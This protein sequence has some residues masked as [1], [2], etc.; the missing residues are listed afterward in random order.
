MNINI[1]VKELE[2][3]KDAS[4]PE[5]IGDFI[6]IFQE[7]FPK[8]RYNAEN[9]QKPVRVGADIKTSGD[10]YLDE[11]RE[12]EAAIKFLE[13]LLEDAREEAVYRQEQREIE[14]EKEDLQKKRKEEASLIGQIQR[15]K[16]KKENG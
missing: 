7:R 11:M 13:G 15:M 4:L 5:E 8:I 14:R 2:G 10:K 6:V 16:E 3:L 12:D 1:K 9:I